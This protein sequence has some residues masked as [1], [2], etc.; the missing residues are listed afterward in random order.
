MESSFTL[1]I[2]MHSA[3]FDR[4]THT[5][6]A[7]IER[8]EVNKVKSIKVRLKRAQKSNVEYCGQFQF[9][10]GPIKVE[11]DGVLACLAVVSIP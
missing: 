11:V 8:D 10:K 6:G 9:H 2:C 1:F 5:R 4:R 3:C 7:T